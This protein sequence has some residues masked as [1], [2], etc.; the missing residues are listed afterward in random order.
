MGGSALVPTP[1]SA[2]SSQVQDSWLQ[3]HSKPI[4]DLYYAGTIELLKVSMRG[5][6]LRRRLRVRVRTPVSTPAARLAYI[7]EAVRLLRI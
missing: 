3:H 2:Y 7:P 5:A 1:D 4:L 6:R